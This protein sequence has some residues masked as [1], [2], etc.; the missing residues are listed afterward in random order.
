VCQCYRSDYDSNSSKFVGN[1]PWQETRPPVKLSGICCG[2]DGKEYLSQEAA[3]Q[4]GT[5]P[6]HGGN[7]GACSSPYDVSIYQ[8]TRHNM[9]DVAYKCMVKF[10][11]ETEKAAFQCFQEM[12]LTS[13]CTQCWIDNM[14]CSGSCCLWKCLW[15]KTLHNLPWTT[16]DTVLNPCIQCDE[17]CCGPNFVQCAGANRRRAGIV[18]DIARPNDDVWKRTEC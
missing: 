4:N 9:S 15:H 14:K 12:G 1:V 17:T 6:L 8:K 7:C 2:E 16:T 11:L 3:C 18:S 5:A 13:G 10:L